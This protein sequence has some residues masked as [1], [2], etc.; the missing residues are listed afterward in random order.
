MEQYFP[1]PLLTLDATSSN[2]L[3]QMLHTQAIFVT[4]AF[5]AHSYPQYLRIEVGFVANGF[6]QTK[7][8]RSM[9]FLR[10]SAEHCFEQKRGGRSFLNHF[11]LKEH[12]Q[13]AQVNWRLGF[14]TY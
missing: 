7:Q 13:L 12:P 6:P 10:E 3:P 1:R 14:R 8:G 4:R 5:L 11:G 9:P 2:G